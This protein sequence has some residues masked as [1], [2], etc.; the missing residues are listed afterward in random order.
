MI[1][2]ILYCGCFLPL[3]LAAQVQVYNG[4]IGGHNTRQGVKRIDTLLRQ[5]KPTIVVIGYGA[6]DAVNSKAQVPASEFK[7]N[8][9]G[10]IAA[11]RKRQVRIIVLNSC[12]PCIDSY[13]ALRHK[14]SGDLKPSERIK[15]YNKLIA[16]TA[17][18]QNVIFND[19]HAAVMKNGG[20]SGDRASL[21][22]NTANSKV[23]DGLH[24]TAEGAKLL[25][26]TVAEALDGKVKNGDRILCLGD[27]ITYGAGLS[28]GGTVTGQTYPAWLKTV[29]NHKYGWSR[30]KTPPPYVPPRPMQISNGSFEGD[31]MGCAP[32]GWAVA[33]KTGT[34]TVAADGK[35]KFL[36]ITPMKVAFC[37]TSNIPAS[38]GKW[39]LRLRARGKGSFQLMCSLNGVKTVAVPLNKNWFVLENDWKPFA[40]PFEVPPKVRSCNVVIRVR[41]GTAD[42]DDIVIVPAPAG[43]LPASAK[44]KTENAEISFFHPNQGGGVISIVKDGKTEFINFEPRKSI[45][46]MTLK[47]INISNLN[48]PEVVPLSVDPERDD[49]GSGKNSEDSAADLYFSAADFANT[50]LELKADGKTVVMSWKN[51]NVGDEKG[52]LDVQVEIKAAKDG[53]SFIFG[54]S[55][56]NRSKKYTVFY[57]DYPAL[58][59]IGGI[60][61]RPD[62]DHLATPF[63]NGRLIR[64]P[65]E[66]GLFKKNRIYQ[67]NR[68]GHS[69]HM[70]VFY[71]S[72]DGLYLGVHDPEQYAKRWDIISDPKSG[73]SWAVRNIP[74]NMRKVPQKWEIPYPTLIRTFNGDWYDGCQIYRDWATAQY[75]CREGK[76]QV[77][78]NLPQ[79][80]RD[81]V[82]WGQYVGI[83]HDTQEPMMCRFRRDFPQYPLGVSLTYWGRSR[84]RFHTGDPDRF[85]I[86][87]ADRQVIRTLKENKVRIMGYIQCTGWTD[88][89]PSF[90]KDPELAKRNLVRNYYGQF[91][92]WPYKNVEQDLIAYPGEVWTKALGD[93]IVKMAEAGFDAAYLDSGN[94]GGTYMNFTPGCSPDSGGGTGYVKG[95]QKLLETLRARARKINPEFCFTSESFWEGNIA[96]LDGYLVCNTTNAYL[97]GDRVTAIPLVQTVYG[98][99]SMMHSVWPSRY[100]TERD[101]ALGYVAKNALALC[102][103]VTPGWN[104]FNLLY[105][106][107]NKEIVQ[108]TSKA[109]YAAYVAG[110]KY[111]V[112]GQ[113]LRQPEIITGV[114][115]LRVKWHRSY[116]AMYHDILMDA[117]I[118][119]VFQAPDGSFALVL[120]NI[121][122]K[123]LKMK[124]DLKKSLPQ[125]RYSYRALYPAEQ[126][127]KL[128]NELAVELE[129]PSR[130]PVIITL[131]KQK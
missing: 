93:N 37:R 131:D 111:F 13:L 89:S 94:H 84:N 96:H 56:K 112:Y 79:W 72:G 16:E 119:T 58:G 74:N 80:F 27:S 87:D 126:K 20:A 75:W 62:L 110:K 117:V 36:R 46:A 33:D 122:E 68:S 39:L 2:R 85:P 23:K 19:F 115:P 104:I 109:R 114:K 5:Y 44:L 57:F 82:E 52:V 123:P 105:T 71:N 65:V 69:M 118:G 6:N 26:E 99:Y 76:T 10:M 113:L 22:R 77:R 125:G 54:G 130:V 106:Y 66:K 81:I 8:L 63:F 100:D 73:V 7:A 59:G 70:D 21:I 116:S 38:D 95:Q 31:S 101:N 64:N 49:N 103:G 47:K 60:N 11:A 18:E 40:V 55:F 97:E 45:W 129:I 9:A 108:A 50:Q 107:G 1:K 24:L 128:R 86:T 78:K 4:G 98:D 121:S 102:W 14:Y 15:E 34:M 88:S 90:R 25:A 51:L 42:L 28:G 41:G 120:Y 17:S 30:E 67:P 43:K 127:F 35:N 83:K 12:N 3:L 61:G 91:L 124:A 32:L 48:L 29:L 92:K 53:Q